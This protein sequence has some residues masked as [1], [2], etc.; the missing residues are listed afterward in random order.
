[1]KSFFGILTK[2]VVCLLICLIIIGA[3]GYITTHPDL[4]VGKLEISAVRAEERGYSLTLTST[5]SGKVDASQY[6]LICNGEYPL[7]GEL[8][9]GKSLTVWVEAEA[10][11]IATL[12]NSDGAQRVP[13]PEM[14][15]GVA[16]LSHAGV[17]GYTADIATDSFNKELLAMLCSP[18]AEVVISEVMP[19]QKNGE[20]WVELYNK[21][22]KD[23]DLSRYSLHNSLAR[24]GVKLE[25]YISGG[26]YLVL[27]LASLKDNLSL[28]DTLCLVKDNVMQHYVKWSEHTVPNISC[29]GNGLKCLYYTSPTPGGKNGEAV[30]ST[31]VTIGKPMVQIS[32]L[33]LKNTFGVAPLTGRRMAWAELYNSS[34]EDIT[35]EGLYLSDDNKDLFKWALPA[36]EIKAGEHA[37]VFFC[38]KDAP[39]DG[40]MAPFELKGNAVYLT[41]IKSLK[42]QEVRADNANENQSVNGD[43]EALDFVSIG[44]KNDT[45]ADSRLM[46]KINEVCSVHAPKSK[47]TDWVE[48]YNPTDKAVSLDG[49]YLTDGKKEPERYALSGSVPAKGYKVIKNSGISI[50]AEGEQIY[51]YYGGYFTDVFNVPRLLPQYTAGRLPEDAELHS[52]GEVTHYGVYLMSAT[53]GEKN[54]TDI[55]LGYADAPVFSKNGGYY[56]NGTTLSITA[57]A[58][59]KIYYTLDGSTP[60]EQSIPYGGEITV[61]E[62]TVVRAVCIR[63][64]YASSPETVGTFRTGEDKHTLPV[65][66]LSINKDD[67]EY[68]SQSKDRLDWRERAGYVEYYNESGELQT[69]FPA[70][71][72]IGGNGTRHYPQRTFNLHMR[73]AYGQ[74]SVIYP[75]FKNNDSIIEY[76]SLSLRNCGQDT[77]Y[78][79]MRDAY[80]SMAMDG[81]NANNAKTF[82]TVVYVNGKY[83][84]LYE[85]K[86]NQNE[87]YLAS[88][89]GCDKDTVQLVRNNTYV[90]NKIGKNTDIKSLIRFALETDCADDAVY[91]EFLTRVDEDAYT[92]YLIAVG[93]F[94][95]NDIYNQKSMRSMDGVAKWQPILFDLDGGLGIY[96]ARSKILSRFFTDDGMYTPSGMKME[97]VIFNAFFENAGWREKF[98]ERYAYLLNTSLSTESLLELF[99]GMTQSIAPEMERHCKRW[100]TPSSVTLWEENVEKMRNVIINRREHAIKEIKDIFKLSDERMAQLFPN[101]FN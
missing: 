95:L 71:L 84:G 68:V 30:E 28:T 67:L 6:R 52:S 55:L 40:L 32:E 57:E 44:V 82:F 3:V 33:M 50:A 1:M 19:R 43:G 65:V 87:D 45:R 4:G 2:I 29:S 75:F 70:G 26:E 37:V 49:V 48:I 74:S 89:T 53:Q 51:L 46:L 38:G 101:D 88:H 91:Q 8:L 25:G 41:D 99:D 80:I 66:C 12:E 59:S 86:E 31:D 16:Y 79:R 92:D 72:S 21:A 60:S 62:T 58:G 7:S 22:D 27:N 97:T 81:T 76:S 73:G 35:L 36:K 93:F 23:I 18:D 90:Y 56:E 63:D 13:L 5:G 9:P 98:V 61:N 100:H 96:S 20:A 34:D 15:L 14:P 39:K 64:G 85:F 17:W 69:A 83:H 10:G 24:G 47:N 11:G 94:V 78:T 77:Y 42:S 54:S